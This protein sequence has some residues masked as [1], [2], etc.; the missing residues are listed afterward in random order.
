M[1]Y[2]FPEG[3]T[4]SY[5]DS[6]AFAAAKTITGFTNANPGVATSTTHGLLDNDIVYFNSAGWPEAADSVFKLDQLTAD[7]FSLT[8][9]DTTN[10]A[11]FP[12]GAGASSTV[13]KISTWVAIPQVLTIA[14]SGGDPRFT[15]ISPL[16]RRTAIQVPTG[17]NPTN[18]TLTIGY[19]SSDATLQA[20]MA[21]SRVLTPVAFKLALASGAVTYGYGYMAVSEVPMLAQGQA[22]QITAVFSLLGKAVTYGS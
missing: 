7:T 19:D 11:T 3:A 15:T 12:A 16:A 4:F 14:T 8:G 10:V 18:I 17:F 5:A 13:K 21:L 9:L 6:T 2:S 22:N 1:S 20:M